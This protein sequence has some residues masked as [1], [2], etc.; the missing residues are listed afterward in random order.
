VGKKYSSIL[1][2]VGGKSDLWTPI[3]QKEKRSSGWF[4]PR[5]HSNYI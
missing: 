1:R 5:Q 2:G 4:S 3:T